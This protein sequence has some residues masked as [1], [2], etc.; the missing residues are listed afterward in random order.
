MVVTAMGM[1][2]MAGVSVMV[3]VVATVTTSV[4]MVTT[5]V[6]VRMRI[7]LTTLSLPIGSLP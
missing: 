6:T 4:R 1:T 5:V 2:A 3:A 7:C